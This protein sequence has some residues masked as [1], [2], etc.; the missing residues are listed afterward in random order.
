VVPAERIARRPRAPC[1]ALARLRVVSDRRRL[2]PRLRSARPGT[3]RFRVRIWVAPGTKRVM[4]SNPTYPV[5]T[6]RPRDESLE[7][8]LRAYARPIER[9]VATHAYT[10]ADRDDLRQEL[11]LALHRALPSFRGECSEKTFILRVTHNQAVRFLARRGRASS[12]ETV[13]D[14]RSPEDT[15]RRIPSVAYER[16]E[17]E[18]ALLAA[19]RALPLPARQ[20]VTLLLEGLTQREIAEVLG[21]TESAVAVRIHRAKAA[22]RVL[23]ADHDP[24]HGD[25][26]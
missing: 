13:D 2:G 15:A 4:V 10:T 12:L 17:R 11:A 21:V 6:A 22:L 7:R 26:R 1:S 20:T 16:Q 23:L 14:E 18:H 3:A 8:A 9:L 24:H 25:Q 5:A 19:V